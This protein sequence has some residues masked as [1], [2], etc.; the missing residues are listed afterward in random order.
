MSWQRIALV[1][2]GRH[3][4]ALGEALQSRG[5]LS[6]ET[7]DADAGMPEERAV[8]GEPGAEAAPWPRARV[9][10]L[11]SSDA[12]ARGALAEALDECAAPVLESAIHDVLADQDWVALTQ[13]QFWPIRAGERL[14]IV[15]SWHRP[16]EPDAVNVM[17]DPGAAFGTGW[18]PTTRLCLAWLERHVGSED[19]VLDYGC[20]SGILAIAALK[21]GARAAAGVDV[22]PRALEA[23]RYNASVNGVPL[24]VLEAGA[25]IAKRAT[26][27]VANI[28][29]NPLRV[30]A[31]LVAAGTAPNGRIALSGILEDQAAD[32]IAA[33]AP[34]ADL[35]IEAREGGWILL[36]GRARG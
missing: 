34:Y 11:F 10:A 16:P 4:E 17:M 5:A 24:E 13:R 32:V 9:I 36:A 26:I 29:A 23:A 2:E 20:G 31:P 21:L 12:D 22:D 27:T 1:V 14:W 3:A 7:T 28:L 15:P 30:L 19:V 33:Y 18:H 6:V 35:A 25:P 8:F